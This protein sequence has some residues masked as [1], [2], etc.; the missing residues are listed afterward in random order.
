M[1]EKFLS[2][3]SFLLR[4]KKIAAVVFTFCFFHLYVSW[5]IL[6]LVFTMS[7]RLGCELLNRDLSIFAWYPQATN[8]DFFNIFFDP[9][10]AAL[11]FRIQRAGFWMTVFETGH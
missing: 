3:R 8:Y 7:Y 9:C 2:V 6:G 10:A 11:I 1:L 5:N 4:T